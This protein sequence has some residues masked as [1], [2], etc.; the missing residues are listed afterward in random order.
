MNEEEAKQLKVGDQVFLL[1]VTERGTP[2]VGEVTGAM[3]V[4]FSVRW[5]AF[6]GDTY[7]HHNPVS[8]DREWLTR[9]HTAATYKGLLER[10]ERLEAVARQA[11][12]FTEELESLN[13][14]HAA[15]VS[16]LRHRGEAFQQD[17]A[18]LEK[19]NLELHRENDELRQCNERGKKDNAELCRANL[20]MEADGRSAAEISTLRHQIDVLLQNQNLLKTDNDSLRQ[21]VKQ[22]CSWE[23]VARSLREDLRRMADLPS[24]ADNRDIIAVLRG[25][26]ARLENIRRVLGPEPRRPG[27]GTG[28]PAAGGDFFKIVVDTGGGVCEGLRQ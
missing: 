24:D 23:Q 4:G 2:V 13:R 16:V 6:T 20:L 15:E 14:Y 25:Q 9:L 7:L 18:R 12:K 17:N 8:S 21:A 5:P 22:T 11:K 28:T 10:L 3:P 19:D 27:A 26:L 1:P